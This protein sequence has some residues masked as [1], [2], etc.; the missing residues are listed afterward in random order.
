MAFQFKITVDKTKVSGT[1]S[2]FPYLFNTTTA[3]IPAGFWL[4]VTDPDGGDI[5]F[6]DTNGATELKREIVSFSSAG[7]T[8]EAIV[9]VP[10]L[11]DT[12]D[13]EIWC[14]YGGAVAA[15]DPAMWSMVSAISVLHSER[16]TCGGGVCTTV[17]SVFGNAGCFNMDFPAGIIGNCA[18]YDVLPDAISVN[19]QIL[20]GSFTFDM[21]VYNSGIGGSVYR[22][23]IGASAAGGPNIMFSLTDNDWLAI[24]GNIG[25]GIAMFDTVLGWK[26]I[27][28]G[29]AYANWSGAW[30]KVTATWNGHVFRIY[31][32]GNLIATSPSY[33]LNHVGT[34][35]K[36]AGYG[37]FNSTV[38]FQWLGNLDEMRIYAGDLAPEFILTEYNNQDDPATFSS[39]GPE[40]PY[41]PGAISGLRPG[42]T[43]GPFTG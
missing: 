25:F 13:K 28:T 27:A 11:D 18:H 29:G 41:P 33:T 34:P 2:Y 31:V 35:N 32:N 17:D 3:S 9:I 6:Y 22:T 4:H 12:Q 8:V 15:Y 36:S 30:F 7:H 43:R 16:Q 21:W 19:R 26:G 23:M 37:N 5:R 14:R 38:R 20:S 10:A 42:K 24:F 39:C 1:H 40:S